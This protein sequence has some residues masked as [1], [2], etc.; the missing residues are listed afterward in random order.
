MTKKLR[1]IENLQAEALALYNAGELAQAEQKYRFILGTN[2]NNAE[3][4]LRDWERNISDH[5]PL[6]IE[7]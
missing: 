5:H 1:E 4:H 7:L 2:I 3:F 6:F